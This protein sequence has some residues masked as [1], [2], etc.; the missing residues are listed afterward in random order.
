[1]PIYEYYCKKCDC[2]LERL[3]KIDDPLPD[4]PTSKDVIAPECELKKVMSR[5]SFR[6]K[7]QGWHKD[8]Y[9]KYPWDKKEN[10]AE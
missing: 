6:L 2:Y 10:G 9:T 7:G 5:N 4:C 8:G 1:M 3:Q